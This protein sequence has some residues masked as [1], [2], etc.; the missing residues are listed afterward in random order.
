[1]DLSTAANALLSVSVSTESASS[2]P[3]ARP[4]D[5]TGYYSRKQHGI[6]AAVGVNHDGVMCMPV[7]VSE[8]A[9]NGS[10]ASVPSLPPPNESDSNATSVNDTTPTDA[11]AA[12]QVADDEH[13]ASND[14]NAFS[15]L[16]LVNVMK[17]KCDAKGCAKYTNDYVTTTC[18]YSQCF[19][20][21]HRPCYEALISKS[22]TTSTVFQDQ[23][24][25]TI[26]H[27]Q[28]HIKQTNIGTLTWTNDGP[29]GRD[30][31]HHSQYHLISHFAKPDALHAYRSGEGGKTKIETATAIANSI[32]AKGVKVHR[33]GKDVKSK[34]EW[35]ERCMRETHDFCN[36]DTGQGI[37]EDEGFASF[38]E[39][40]SRC[41]FFY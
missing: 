5:A 4:D 15:A 17:Y 10:T 29:K 28:K 30:D 20:R 22:K 3:I 24:F 7:D 27:Q 19:K 32:N 33:T 18:A 14:P 23:V 1:M 16:A 6:S 9:I 8:F 31:P 11:A 39:K 34:I 37:K 41:I 21:V 2:P 38:E 12:T 36:S 40:A 25:C 13:A 26:D 35:I